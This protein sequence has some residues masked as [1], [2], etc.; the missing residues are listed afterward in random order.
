MK[1][2]IWNPHTAQKVLTTDHNQQCSKA[3]AQEKRK[4]VHVEVWKLEDDTDLDGVA[5][6]QI[7][8]LEM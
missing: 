3:D 8:S 4:L 2:I 1:D 5:L 6:D 7:G